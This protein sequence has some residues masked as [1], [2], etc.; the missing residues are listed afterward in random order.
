MYAQLFESD[1]RPPLRAVEEELTSAFTD[2]EMT[3]G[4]IGLHLVNSGGKRLRPLLTVLSAGAAGAQPLAV[5]KLAAGVELIHMATLVHDDVID[6]AE[7]RRGR[8]TVNQRWGNE[9]S[10]MAGD[11]LLAR[12]LNMVVRTCPA[13]VIGVMS[14]MICRMCEGEISQMNGTFDLNVDEGSYLDRIRRKTALFLSVCCR[15][16]AIMA[17]AGEQQVTALAGYGLNLGMAFQII[18]DL[19]DLCGTEDAMGKTP[20][21]DLTAG[22]IT[23]PLIHSLQNEDI[24]ERVLNI[25]D[26]AQDQV[27]PEQVDEISAVLSENGSFQ[28]CR[29]MARR[30]VERAKSELGQVVSS[31][32][33]RD[34]A[35]LADMVLE[36][37]R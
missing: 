25:L 27:T 4:C 20:G 37:D 28:Y 29:E 7:K 17:G 14:E 19:L 18:D 33:Q 32:W 23:L 16:G 1:V 12:A 2:A 31:S 35:R 26:N 11:Y 13:A 34:L 6:G 36:R 24:R 9:V 3:T 30:Y 22:V 21:S 5:T 8:A 10:V 15:C